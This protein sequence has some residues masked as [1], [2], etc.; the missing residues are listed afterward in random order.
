VFPSLSPLPFDG[1]SLQLFRQRLLSGLR[2]RS[3]ALAAGGIGIGI[4]ATIGHYTSDKKY[5]A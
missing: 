1:A 2:H 4:L 3:Q 5:D